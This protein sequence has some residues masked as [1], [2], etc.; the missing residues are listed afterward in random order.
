MKRLITVMALGLSVS[1]YSQQWKTLPANVRILGYRNVTTSKVKSNYNQFRSESSLGT[2]IRLDAA[3]LNDMA[4]NIIVPGQDISAEAYNNFLLGEYKVDPTAQFN[5]NGFGLGWGITNRIMAYAEFSYYNA[6]VK[7]KLRRTKGN[8]YGQTA[9]GFQN[10]NNG[11]V[12]STL[13]DNLKSLPD[14]D[15]GVIQ[16]ALVNEM[17]YKPLGN[18]TGKGYGDMETGI[19]ANVYDGGT[20][21][22]LVYPGAVLPTGRTDDP[23]MLQDVGFGD[24]QTDLFLETASGYI[25]NDYLSFGTTLRYTYQ[26]PYNTELR[27]PGSANSTVSYDKGDFDVKYGD[28]INWMA[29]ATYFVN[30]WLAFTPVYRV[31]MQKES[32]YQS[33]IKNDE[34][35]RKNVDSWLSNNSDKMEHQVQLTTSISS[36]QP[37]LK[38][39]FLLPAQFNVNVVQTVGGKN[40]PKVGRF[41]FELRMLF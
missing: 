26:M 17:G 23:D 37:F 2:T 19:M 13:G 10:N 22:L 39:K 27:I 14:V 5:V 41:E 16:S 29:N 24:G 12:D 15:A 31:M 32:Q 18:W 35:R 9:D 11:V 8:T 40:V 7:T 30:D 21:G 1:A 4:G 33:D 34:Q 20:W 25:V 38:K 36:I 3:T 6:Q 28:K